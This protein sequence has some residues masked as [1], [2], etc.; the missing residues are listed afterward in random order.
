MNTLLDWDINNTDEHLFSKDHVSQELL[1][2][3]KANL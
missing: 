1:A 2:L 3:Y